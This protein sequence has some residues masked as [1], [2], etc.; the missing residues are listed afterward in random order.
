[1]DLA[2]FAF[3]SDARQDF[4]LGVSDLPARYFLVEISRTLSINVLRTTQDNPT[5]FLPF[6]E[7]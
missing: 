6:P 1:M 3:T 5:R 4:A 7:T 2:V